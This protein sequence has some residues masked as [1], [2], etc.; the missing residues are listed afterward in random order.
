MRNFAPLLA[1]IVALLGMT[2]T[3]APAGAIDEACRVPAELVRNTVRLE[4]VARARRTGQPIRIV[5]LGTASSAGAG[6]STPRAAYPARLEQWLA[7]HWGPGKVQVI[8]VSHAGQTAAQ[9]ADR[10]AAVIRQEQPQLVVWQTG[11]V[12]AI[13]GVDVNDFG[14]AIE[15][16]IRLAAEANVDLLLVDSQ[17]GSPAFVLRDASPYLDYLDQLVRGRDV[18]L[19]HRYA[20]MKYWVDNG[21]LNLSELPRAEQQ[22]VADQAHDCLAQLMAAV[23]AK[24]AQ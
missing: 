24:A 16:G 6:L 20:I 3:C 12:D 23:I 7:Q 22:R 5:V 21:T 13:R 17:Y 1:A 2:A 8:N 18:V 19:F 14:D 4:Q 9:M 11:T 15:R 10:M